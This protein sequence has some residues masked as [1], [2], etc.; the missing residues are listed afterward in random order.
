MKLAPKLFPV[1]T[2]SFQELL[3]LM[4]LSLFCEFH[5]K[6]TS[7]YVRRD[8]L[9]KTHPSLTGVISTEGLW[10]S[11]CHQQGHVMWQWYVVWSIDMSSLTRA[12]GVFAWFVQ[13][14]PSGGERRH[15]LV[16]TCLPL[17]SPRISL[18]LL[19]HMHVPSANT[20]SGIERTCYFDPQIKPL[21]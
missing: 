8:L 14:L 19:I 12:W 20:Q 17:S 11:I 2:F 7:T 3:I 5:R 9:L 21:T 6:S 1:L 18:Y 13:Q 4:K 16:M 10:S 15:W